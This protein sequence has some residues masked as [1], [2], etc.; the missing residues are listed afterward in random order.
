MKKAVI[1][2]VAAVISTAA[3]CP[4]PAPGTSIEGQIV[5]YG[6]PVLDAIRSAQK[7]MADQGDQFPELR[8]QLASAIKVT[9]ASAKVAEDLGNVLLAMDKTEVTAEKMKLADRAKALL[10]TLDLSMAEILKDVND[11]KARDFIVSVM[12]QVQW[13]RVAFEL[14]RAL[15][16]FLPQPK[17]GADGVW[18]AY[19]PEFS[20]A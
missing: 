6:Q 1:F 18:N 16:P 4:K 17:P 12:R 19:R 11:Q 9:I 14:Y 15:S 10:D 20:Y 8:P 2:L 7:A 3:S 13:A 5:I